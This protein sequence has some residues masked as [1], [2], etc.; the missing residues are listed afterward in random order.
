MATTPSPPTK[1]LP[2]EGCRRSPR[3]QGFKPSY[4]YDI[5][6]TLGINKNM[7]SGPVVTTLH[8]VSFE[9]TLEEIILKVREK[10]PMIVMKAGLFWVK[11]EAK[12]CYVL[13]SS[14]DL[15]KALS[16][17]RVKA[18]NEVK[19]VRLAI[20]YHASNSTAGKRKGSQ[21][22]SSATKA[23]RQIIPDGNSASFDITDYDETLYKQYIGGDKSDTGEHSKRQNSKFNQS[24][25]H[26]MR[27]LENKRTKGRYGMKHLNLWV[28][29][30][31][32]GDLV[33]PTEEPNW[34][35]H[36]DEIDILP[37]V[38]IKLDHKKDSKGL[39]GNNDT[40]ELMNLFFIREERRRRHDEDERR[41]EQ[42][43]RDQDF[44]TVLLTCLSPRNAIPTTFNCPENSSFQSPGGSSSPHQAGSFRAAKTSMP[45][46]GP[47]LSPPNAMRLSTDH[48]IG[49]LREM[50]PHKYESK[51]REFNLDGLTLS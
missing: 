29:L 36:L 18:T 42:E 28:Q 34:A 30:I 1:K 49:V 10:D 21:E 17:Y 5:L 39:K 51:F 14:E 27:F 12:Q 11:K 23:K 48:V 38:G 35:N 7:A 22:S 26:L 50:G 33:G 16:Q 31:T 4:F 19:D 37:R 20:H 47:P 24:L 45:S 3:Q 41:R 6:L 13:K 40:D 8:N 32:T 2:V 46:K 15:Q 25:V 9:S 43:R 44:R